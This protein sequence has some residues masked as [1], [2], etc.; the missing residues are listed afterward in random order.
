MLPTK[1]PKLLGYSWIVKIAKNKVFDEKKVV[2]DFF[3]DPQTYTYRRQVDC[4]IFQ[5]QCEVLQSH[6]GSSKMSTLEFDSR[7]SPEHPGFCQ[8]GSGS[9]SLLGTATIHPRLQHSGAACPDPGRS[10]VGG[11]W[12]FFTFIIRLL[13]S[14]CIDLGYF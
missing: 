4:G 6:M 10:K 1:H 14:V 11:S 2:S 12:F 3:S 7:T 9:R 8:E 5:A 13:I